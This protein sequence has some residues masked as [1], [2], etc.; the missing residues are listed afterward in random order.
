M[1]YEE[2]TQQTKDV[3]N[4]VL[5]NSLSYPIEKKMIEVEI[6]ADKISISSQDT[7]HRMVVKSVVEVTEVFGLGF[8][9]DCE[10]KDIVIKIY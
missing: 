2:M 9:V 7:M 4:A 6:T 1:R 8:W 5:A 3:F 10:K